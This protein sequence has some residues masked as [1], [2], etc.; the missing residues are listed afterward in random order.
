ML[1]H[2]AT[3][4]RTIKQ[5][6]Y[7]LGVFILFLFPGNIFAADIT[8]TPSVGQFDV[9]QSFTVDVYVTNNTQAINAVS[10]TLTF[11]T[12]TLSVRSISKDGTIIKLWPE[13]P[14]FSNTSGLVKFEGVILNPGFSGTRGK[15]ISLSF[16]AK[17][18]G[19]ANVIFSSGQVLANDGQATNVVG[20][21]GN[22]SYTVATPTEDEQPIVSVPVVPSSQAPELTSPTHP[23]QN[24]WYASRD[25][26]F[27]WQLPRGVTAVRTLYDTSASSRPTRVYDPAIKERSFTTDGDDVYYMHVQFKDAQG[28]GD[29]AHYRFQID[30]K[31]PTSLKATFPDGSV[32]SHPKPSISIIASDALSGID[33]YDI[34]VDGTATTT[35]K[36]QENNL[37]ALPEQ[38]AGKHTVTV[39]A[40]DK[41]GNTT[42]LALDYTIIAITVP[43][44]TDYTKHAEL[45][46]VVKVAGT[47]YPQSVVEVI[48]FNT[49]SEELYKDTTVSDVDGNFSLLWAKKLPLGVY[50][51]KVRVMDSKGATSAYSVPHV[52][53]I[54]RQSYVQL[55]MFVMNWLSL[56]LIL[57]IAT[58]CILATL[59]YSF[60]Q[61]NR[62][63]RKIHRTIQETENTLKA[64]V[65]ALRRD[66][67]EFHTLLVKAEKK[68]ELTKEEQAI[69]KKFKKRLEITE[70]EIEKKLEQ[71]G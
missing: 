11:P 21:L 45:G 13:E 49:K 57:V 35:Y 40:R 67:E 68:R 26:T 66:T 44:V 50:E 31:A 20:S 39:Y 18:A 4:K 70:K 3:V 15:V 25:V 5:F 53:T 32:T 42:K 24:A 7:V 30:T 17:K 61:F 27:E 2:L 60:I 34:V 6:L 19:N 65:A 51:M 52:V 43:T 29:I 69:L 23:D 56:I 54:E 41:A 33:A 1:D 9:G 63:R 64:N 48:Y 37:Y 47:T 12:D 38:P 16:S 14:S 71:I 46:D 58:A 28:W 10:G 22:G 36:P 59:W 8:L 55:G 62:F